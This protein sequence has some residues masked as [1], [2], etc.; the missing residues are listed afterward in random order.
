MQ[1]TVRIL[2]HLFLVLFPYN[3]LCAQEANNVI[4]SGKIVFERRENTAAW[5]NSNFNSTKIDTSFKTQNFSCSF[6]GRESFYAPGDENKGSQANLFN[7]GIAQ[8]NTKYINLTSRTEKCI[9]QIID[10]EYLI[11]DTLRTIKWKITSDIREIA[12]FQCRK[13]T[14]VIL[15]SIYVVAFYSDKILFPGGPESFTGLPGMI[16]GVAIPRLHTTWFATKVTPG[17][18]KDEELKPPTRG[19]KITVK[20]YQE[21]VKEIKFKF[22]EFY[23][24]I[25]TPEHFIWQTLL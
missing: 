23:G 22:K 15:D 9:K 1:M 5:I 18:V 25:K 13:A 6:K 4:L 10:D 24:L 17:E 8:R 19:K 16:L 14:A 7:F 20:E 11:N 2:L 21:L 3:L 12:G